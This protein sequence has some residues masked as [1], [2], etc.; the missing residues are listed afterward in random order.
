VL[1]RDTVSRREREAWVTQAVADGIRVIIS[2][3]KLVQTGLDLLNFPTIIW[4]S[5]GYELPVLRQ[6]SRRAWRIGQQYPCRVLFLAYTDTLQQ[7]ALVLMGRKMEAALA[8]EGQLSLT[9]LQSLAADGAT[10]NELARALA[11]GLEGHVTDVSAVWATAPAPVIPANAPGTAVAVSAAMPPD[12]ARLPLLQNVPGPDD[13][14]PTLVVL[15]RSASRR[16]PARAHQL[17]WAF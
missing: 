11:Y 13:P 3:P 15:T 12:V 6:A 9:G 5:T 10:G 7:D 16:A 17:S 4:Y 2:H 14:S 8:L 1:R